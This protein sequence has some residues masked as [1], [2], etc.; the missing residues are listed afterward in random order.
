MKMARWSNASLRRTLLTVLV[1][2]L[3]AVLGL[4][5]VVNWR[6]TLAGANAAFDRSLLGA[7]KAM[8]A[9]I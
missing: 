8:D 7:V 3:L 1:P 5:I 2:G 9:N 4:D 6:N